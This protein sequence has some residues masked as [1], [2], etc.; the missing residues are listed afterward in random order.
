MRL[1]P[2]LEERLAAD[3][4][5]QLNADVETPLID[6]LADLEHVGVRVDTD[7]LAELNTE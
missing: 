3:G 6:V 4:L 2:I 1:L 7:R 5:E